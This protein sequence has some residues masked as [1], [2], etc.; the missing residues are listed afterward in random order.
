MEQEANKFDVLE[1]TSQSMCK[2]FEINKRTSKSPIAALFAKN[3]YSKIYSIIAQ[4]VK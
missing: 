4:D 3:S 2:Q 1:F